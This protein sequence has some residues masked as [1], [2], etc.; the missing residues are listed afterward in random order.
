MIIMSI[1]LVLDQFFNLEMSGAGS[2][3]QQSMDI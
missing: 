2:L 3:K 1:L